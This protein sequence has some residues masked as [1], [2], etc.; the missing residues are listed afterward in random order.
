MR[1]VVMEFVAEASWTVSPL[2]LLSIQVYSSELAIANK[3]YGIS[4][5][6]F[7]L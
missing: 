6:V 4:F 3:V 2:F 7:F 1:K 5:L